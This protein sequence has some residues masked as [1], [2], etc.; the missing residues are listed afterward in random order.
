MSASAGANQTRAAPGARRFKRAA[1][2]AVGVLL[3][4]AISALLARLLTP[5]NL[6]REKDLALIQAEARGDAP[7]MIDQLQRLQQERHVRGERA[8]KTPPIGACGARER[9]RSCR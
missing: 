9:S 4:L 3:F 1:L 8:A 5:D 7:S 2:I 6:E